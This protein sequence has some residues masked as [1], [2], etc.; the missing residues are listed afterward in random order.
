MR[1]PYEWLL[2]TRYL[3]SAHRSG[4]V[5]FVASMAVLGLALAVAVL[6]VVLSVINGFQTEVRSRMLAVTSHATITGIHGEIADWRR[7]QA[8]AARMPGVKAVVPYVE[9]RGLLANGERVAGTLV[10]GILP[11]EEARAV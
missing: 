10:R 2:A 7:G 11:D 9:S 5:S 6:I 8:E 1:G 4:F 3:R